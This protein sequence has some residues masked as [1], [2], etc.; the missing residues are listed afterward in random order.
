[1]ARQWQRIL[2][3][4]LLTLAVAAYI[5]LGS[6]E[7]P[8]FPGSVVAQVVESKEAAAWVYQRLPDLPRENQYVRRETGKVASDNTL[9]ERLIQYHVNV[10]GRSPLH[11]LDWKMTLADY[12]GVNDYLR[13]AAYPGQGFL[14]TNPMEGDRAVIQQF[15]RWQREALVQALTDFF[16]RGRQQAG[17]SLAPLPGAVPSGPGRSTPAPSLQPLPGAGAADL[18]LP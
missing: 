10:K 4:G 1:M 18:L 8:W 7:F 13:E 15:N 17:P 3:F 9:V 12:L 2:S 11:R 6:G 16:T 14:R 5:A